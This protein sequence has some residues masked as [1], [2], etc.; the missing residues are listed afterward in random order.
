MTTLA[1]LDSFAIGLPAA[2]ASLPVDADDFNRFVAELQRRWRAEPGYERA[3]ERKATLLLGR[4]RRDI[5]KRGIRLA[6][7]YYDNADPGEPLMAV[8]TFAA[9]TQA[10]L[11]TD[12]PLT[13]PTLFTA[14]AG[15]QK[16]PSAAGRTTNVEPPCVHRLPCGEAVRLRRLY[17]P[18]AT[19]MTKESC[20]GE[21]FV[22]PLADDGKAAAVLQFATVNIEL[23]SQFSVLFERIAQTLTLLT[24]DMDTHVHRPQPAGADHG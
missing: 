20:Y 1:D 14:F 24:P 5:G 13:T 9:Y 6:A 16:R 21:S 2:W 17:Q 8:A 19:S 11:D 10:D 7:M 23:A 3:T 15:S 12:L 22:A 18:T 4:V